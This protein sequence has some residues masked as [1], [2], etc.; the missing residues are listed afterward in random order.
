MPMTLNL[1][2]KMVAHIDGTT[3]AFSLLL[4]AACGLVFG[5]A[6]ALH[7]AGSNVGATLKT[8]G[9]GPGPATPHRLRDV[10][11]GV[12]VALAVVVLVL[13]G[14]F[15]KSF[16]NSQTTD[17]GFNP[18]NVLLAQFDLGAKGYDKA[19]ARAFVRDLLPR[20]RALPG[21]EM[22]ATAGFVPLDFRGLAPS[23]YAVD[24]RPVDPAAPDRSLYTVVSPGY[25]QT[26]DI[27]L[28]AG[29][30][31]VDL[32]DTDKPAEV[33]VNQELARRAWSGL[34]PLGRRFSMDGQT[35][36]VVG[37]ARDAKYASLSERPTPMAYISLR[38]RVKLN[39]TLFLRIHGDPL[40]CAPAVRRAIREFDP[41]LPV[42]DVRTLAQH[43]ADN[44]FMLR[45]PARLLTVLGPLALLLAAIGIYSVLS[46]A[47]A[48][49]LPEIGVR[50]ALG[51]TPAE[52]VTLVVGQGLAVVAAGLAAGLAA[53]YLI[54]AYLAPSLVNVPAGDP[55]VI[56]GAA[57]VILAVAALACWLPARHASQVDPIA[58]LRAE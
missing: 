46:Y 45:V 26:V 3:L 22:A 4:G 17:P 38:D 51:A 13:A 55:A 1:P 37:V 42:R 28:V 47:T 43:V 12:E 34:S 6:P 35:Y 9:R 30:D 25:L 36:E 27:P 2:V 29:R 11:V 39:Q 58:A 50:L 48:Q 24:G 10:L 57:L 31:F 5:L 52:I 49:R 14:L 20:L 54:S 8:G 16:R 19:N 44:T 53:A 23:R 18:R 41:Y 15:L 33:I 21:V 7:L 56:L 32:A 40:A